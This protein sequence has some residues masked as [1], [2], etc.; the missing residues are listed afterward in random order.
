MTLA[1]FLDGLRCACCGALNMLW[2][3]PLRGLVECRECGQSALAFPE[4]GEAQ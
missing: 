1:H 2:L 3:D 4:I